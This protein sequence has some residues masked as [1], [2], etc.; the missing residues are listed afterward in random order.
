M[1]V[2]NEVRSVLG[3]VRQ[4]WFLWRKRLKGPLNQLEFDALIRLAKRVLWADRETRRE[5]Q[6]HKINIVPVNFYSNIPSVNDVEC[7]FEYRGADRTDGSYLS[8]TVFSM[9]KTIS[10]LEEIAQ[11]A[12]EFSPPLEKDETNPSCFYWKNPSFSFMDAMSYYCILRHVNP[13]RVLEI[14]SGNSSLVADMALRENGTGDLV[15]VE[16]YPMDILRNIEK[17]SEIHECFVQDFEISELVSLVESADVL[18]IDST[19][20]V[21]I[22][23]DCL[24][25]YLKLLP[26]IKKKMIVHSHDIALPYAQPP[27]KTDKHI[28]WTEQYLLYAYLLD[29]PK[30]QVLTGSYFIQRKLPEISKKMMRGK[31]ADGG[32][33]FWYQLN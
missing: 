7:S 19:H 23:S 1:N 4:M 18:F 11:Y 20:T 10:F 2:L 33:S 21:K 3:F 17:V 28:Y 9:E 25:I 31:Y 6:S 26:E 27:A 12:D 13:T 30:A 24:Y 22:G 8:P 16:P 15:L 14:G 32:G 5:I 29:N